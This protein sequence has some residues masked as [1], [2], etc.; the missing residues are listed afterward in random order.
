[1]DRSSQNSTPETRDGWQP[2]VYH[3]FKSE[4]QQPAFDLMDLL[5]DC[6]TGARILDLGCGTGELT[7]RLHE[8]LGASETL[9]IDRSAAMLQA[10]RQQTVAGL[11]FA[12]QDIATLIADPTEFGGFDIV[13]SNAA[14]QW[15]PDHATLW[16]GLARLVAPGGQLAIQIPAM[17]D[18]VTHIACEEVARTQPFAE[19]LGGFSDRLSILR[20]EQ[21]AVLLFGLGFRPPRVELR[22]YP[23]ELRAREE[24]VEWFRGSM[25]TAYETRLP[26]DLFAAFILAWRARVFAF[27]PD[28]RPCFLG[29]RRVLMS[30]RRAA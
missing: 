4:R 13:F 28:E 21:Y 19:A 8:R 30:G 14:L 3:R 29:F 25:L 16:P 1:M 11:S 10:A 15:L 24:L 9:G 26:P 20:P 2:S 27:Y 7:R 6:G 5:E 17:D 18:D 12:Q 22:V 23:H